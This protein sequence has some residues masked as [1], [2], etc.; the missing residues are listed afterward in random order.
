MKQNEFEDLPQLNLYRY[1]NFFNIYTDERTG[2]RFY[3]ILKSVNIFP[4]GSADVE[5]AHIISESDTWQSI[6]YLHY[7]I[8][9]LWWLV[10]AYNSINNP[11]LR[12]RPGSTIKILNKQY[13]SIVLQ[14]LHNQ[15]NR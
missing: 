11:V 3:N 8:M 15:L 10:C 2:E 12:P 6:S 5:T 7:N 13:V 9:D 14:E 1:E 4:S